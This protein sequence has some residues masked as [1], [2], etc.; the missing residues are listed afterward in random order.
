[1]KKRIK[2]IPKAIGRRSIS[3]VNVPTIK[4]LNEKKHKIVVLRKWGGVGDIVNTRPLFKTIKTLYPYLHVTYALPI[5]Y[6]PI[7]ED[8]IYIDELIN[9]R[10]VDFNKYGYAVDISSDCGRYENHRIPYVDKHRSDIWAEVSLGIK[11]IDHDF[12][13][14]LNEKIVEE[15]K[16]ILKDEYDYDPKVKIAIFP[17][18]ASQSKDIPDNV[19]SELVTIMI[20]DG[21]EPCIIHN[22]KNIKETRVP[23]IK[24]LN[25][26]QFVHMISFFDYIISVD[27]GSFHL[28][29]ALSIP[30]V[31]IFA[32]TDGKIL[33]KYHEKFEIVQKHRDFGGPKVCPC[34][35]WPTCVLKNKKNVTIPLK[36]IKAISADDICTKFKE[37]VY[38]NKGE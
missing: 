31:G 37:L 12:H 26:K 11:L 21:H 36:C 15:C 24:D 20:N 32:W 8:S 9:Y 10:N 27:T 28:A 6:H 38:K 22:R 29:A 17:K 3:C 34:W 23:F 14:K 19:L 30:T 5:Q 18:S 2:L 1:M 25:I 16:A 13:I 33:G 35:S 4:Q 7:L